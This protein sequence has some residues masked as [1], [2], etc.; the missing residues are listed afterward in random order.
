MA[1]SGD[2]MTGD[3]APGLFRL[4]GRTAF[5]SGAAGHLGRAM[6]SALSEAGAHIVV[7]GRDTEKLRALVQALE[8]AGGSAESAAFD[9]GDLEACRDYFA[10]R[11]RIDILVNNAISMTPKPFEALTE[12]DFAR[13]YLTGVVA[14]FS[15]VRAALPALKTAARAAGDA[16]VVN[17]ASMYGLVSPDKRIYSNADQAS[18]FHYGPAKAAVIQLSRHL[19]A[20]L[21]PEQI[22][23]NALVPGP[24][25][26]ASV[27]AKD[28]G[29]AGR[30]AA[31]TMLG[32]TGRADE[33]RGPL[34]F[35]ASRASSFLT[36]HALVVDGGWTV[37]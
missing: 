8:T 12:D 9:I 2:G 31:R 24:F 21:G 28:P 37:W 27:A 30:L 18:P 20:E 36:G 4:D 29:F 35:L 7:N 16:S 32:R 19:A 3:P 34:L 6:A 17:V 5:I 23:V 33:I 14:P 13:T 22:R 15:M 25:P 1:E 26:Q 10:S 11:A